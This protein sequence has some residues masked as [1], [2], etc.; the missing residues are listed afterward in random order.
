MDD[1]FQLREELLEFQHIA[2]HHTGVNLARHVHRVLHE[3]DIHDKLYCI[4]TDNAANNTTMMRFLSHLFD[5]EDNMKWSGA[6]HHIPCLAHV[7]NLAV[8]GFLK[9]LKVANLPEEHDIIIVRHGDDDDKNIENVAMGSNQNIQFTDVP[10]EGE[11]YINVNEFA[12]D[13]MTIATMI[14]KL[15]AISKAANFPQ[16]RILAFASFCS[17]A[18]V[19]PLRPIRNQ[20]TRWSATFNMLERAVYLRTPI[21]LWTRSN[22]MYQKLRLLRQG[23]GYG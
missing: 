9:A 3:Y 8:K 15:R 1:N 23:M 18:N 4:T 5:I 6:E 10:E 7:I 13:E 19:K 12:S 20:A 14:Q 16:N 22:S 17:S 11:E 2:E 21:D